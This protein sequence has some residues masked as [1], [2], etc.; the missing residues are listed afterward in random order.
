MRRDRNRDR[1]RDTKE[2]DMDMIETE[3][4]NITEVQTQTD[5]E[6]QAEGVNVAETISG[7]GGACHAC[8]AQE[9]VSF[10]EEVHVY[11]GRPQWPALFQYTSQ[12][13]P[14]EGAPGGP[15]A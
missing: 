4:E 3:A 2:R 7:E 5:Q 8:G 11:N 9:P 13:C 12:A 6:P 14:A 1:D 15:R 10:G